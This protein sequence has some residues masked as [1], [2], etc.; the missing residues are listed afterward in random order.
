MRM[1]LELQNAPPPLEGTSDTRRV[2]NKAKN[3]AA[4]A[5]G[6]VVI[7]GPEAAANHPAVD[8]RSGLPGRTVNSQNAEGGSMQVVG[9]ETSAR[10]AAR[11]T[12]R[13]MAD[14]QLDVKT[15]LPHRVLAFLREHREWVLAGSLGLLALVWLAAST[16]SQR[17]R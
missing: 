5:G 10:T 3:A 15:M 13:Q 14:D 12:P 7:S 17:R 6:D 11:E 16:L 4:R 1:L 8:W 9:R 2:D